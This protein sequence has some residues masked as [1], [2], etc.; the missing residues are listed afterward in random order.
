LIMH[1]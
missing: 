1:R